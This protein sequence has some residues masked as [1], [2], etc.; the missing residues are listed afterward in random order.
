MLDRQFTAHIDAHGAISSAP[1]KSLAARATLG[2]QLRIAHALWRNIIF[3]A[4]RV[5]GTILLR[6]RLQLQL[7]LRLRLRLDSRAGAWCFR[8]W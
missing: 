8:R 2:A 3:T 4:T 7:R 5:L 1:C 6:L